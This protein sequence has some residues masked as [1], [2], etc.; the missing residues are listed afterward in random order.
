MDPIEYPTYFT[1]D[2]ITVQFFESN[3]IKEIDT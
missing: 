1:P 2:P 3:I